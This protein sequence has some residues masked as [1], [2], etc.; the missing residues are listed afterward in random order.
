[1]SELRSVPSSAEK[2]DLDWSQVRETVRMF[3]VGVSAIEYS[4]S[5]GD[6]SITSLIEAFTN[7]NRYMQEI[8]QTARDVDGEVPESCGTQY[9]EM[10]DRLDNKCDLVISDLKSAVISFQFYD[11]LTQ[12]LNHI[13]G[14]LENTADLVNDQQRLFNPNEWK[15]LQN[16]V[17]S[18]FTMEEGKVLFDALLRGATKEEAIQEAKAY[19]NRNADDLML[20]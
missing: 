2:P 15:E 10:L 19:G 8:K 9:Q 13:A 11:R 7:M 3:R 4:M 18:S 1:M 5:T 6:E 20:F 16:Q 14:S 17:Y 12:Q